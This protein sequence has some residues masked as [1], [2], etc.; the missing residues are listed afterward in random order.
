MN[1]WGQKVY[2]AE[3]FFGNSNNITID[4]KDFPAGIYFIQLSGEDKVQQQP[5]LI[6][7]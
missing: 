4:V 1:Q 5:L 6:E 3:S 2:S 7:R